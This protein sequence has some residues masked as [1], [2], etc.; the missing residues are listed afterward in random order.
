MLGDC[1]PLAVPDTDGVW[2]CVSDGVPVR[3][4]VRFWLLVLLCDADC[5][6]VAVRVTEEVLDCVWERV[7][8]PVRVPL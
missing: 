8:V 6:C 3:L 4:A 5:V 1:V 2:L 7:D